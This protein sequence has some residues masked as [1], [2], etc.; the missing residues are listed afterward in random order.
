MLSKHESGQRH[1]NAM[2]AGTWLSIG[3]VLLLSGCANAPSVLQPHGPAAARLAELWWVLLSVAAIVFV[4]VMGLLAYA[5][6]R[7]RPG[8]SRLGNGQV[9]II[10]GGAVVP[11]IILVGVM[12]YTVGV[13]RAISVP[14]QPPVLT[15]EVVGHQWWWEVFYPD[16]SFATANEMHIPVGQP[17]LIKLTT[18]D[19][20][21]S[22]WAPEL[23]AKMDLLPGQTN[24]TWIQANTPG[25]YRVEC[26]EYCG[27][28]HA[29]MSMMIVAEAEEQLAAW[30]THQQ[31]DAPIVTDPVL[32]QGQQ[33]FMGSACVYCHT[34]RGT[35]ASGQLGPDLT[36]LGSR[37]TIGAGILPNT[38]G[39]LAGWVINAQAMKPGN[40]MPPMYL[41][42][43]SL[44]TMLAYLESLE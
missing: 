7:R 10:T 12:I 30:L 19:V 28:Q 1:R 8:P 22:F 35:T 23:Q 24:T 32:L 31:Q 26:A 43:S 17:V 38:R 3:A 42:A 25:I 41:D 44:H 40:R 11:A 21:H 20:I 36:H 2:R 15:I 5:L 14:Q 9:F 37:L 27:V 16:Q 18:A 34:I 6:L 29:H 13:Q 4:I 39:H 33:V